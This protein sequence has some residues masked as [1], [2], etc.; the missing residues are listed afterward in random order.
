MCYIIF[1]DTQYCDLLFLILCLSGN[2]VILI[3]FK[4][5]KLRK[6]F[7]QVKTVTYDSS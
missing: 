6:Y 4:I 2:V 3:R 5:S 1:N 7:K